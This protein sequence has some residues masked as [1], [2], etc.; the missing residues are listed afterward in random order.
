MQLYPASEKKEK[1]D[2]RFFHQN[3]ET[4]PCIT[5]PPEE[6]SKGLKN[7]WIASHGC[8][9]T[10]PLEKG[11][12]VHEGA[13]EEVANDKKPTPTPITLKQMAGQFSISWSKLQFVSLMRLFCLR[14]EDDVTILYRKCR[15]IH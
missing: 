14:Y 13:D 15:S 7:V 5:A 2:D 10:F 6:R 4:I 3:A 1:E 8:L 11:K 12:K 9:I